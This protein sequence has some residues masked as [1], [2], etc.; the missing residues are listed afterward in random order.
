VGLGFMIDLIIDRIS[1]MLDIFASLAMHLTYL[2]LTCL[3]V[4]SFQ[5][6]PFWTLRILVECWSGPMP[7]TAL[8]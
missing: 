5:T 4:C 1:C 8:Q 2:A 7:S 3:F 6:E